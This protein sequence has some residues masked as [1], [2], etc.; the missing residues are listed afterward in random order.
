[1]RVLVCSAVTLLAFATV[2]NAVCYFR[3]LVLTDIMNPP[4]GCLDEDGE[5]HEFRAEWVKNCY[6]CVCFH[7][8]MA[9]C[10][11]FPPAMLLSP[12]CET[13]IDRKTCTSKTVLKS[14]NTKECVDI[15][16]V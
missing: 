4:T 13:V 3:G 11:M 5:M 8:G 6:E 14:D 10:D 15:F 12:D 16:A 2:C 7:R 1:M 9:C